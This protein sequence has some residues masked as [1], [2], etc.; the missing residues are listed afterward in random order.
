MFLDVRRDPG[1]T[2]RADALLRWF[3]ERC[4][5][6]EWPGPRLPEA[7]Y[8]PRSLGEGD[9]PRASLHAKCVVVDGE[10]TFIGSANFTEAAQLR[11]I[12]SGVVICSAETALAV[13]WHFDGLV[14]RT[15]L[16]R[17]SLP[18][19]LLTQQQQLRI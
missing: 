5:R 8:H 18:T 2:T 19:L 3:A 1:D 4:V 15:H 11:N 9:A 17:S 10:R 13:E 16:R 6:Q 7:Y 12:E 14:G